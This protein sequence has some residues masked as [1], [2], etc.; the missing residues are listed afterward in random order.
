MVALS[1]HQYGCRVVQRLLEHC[2][3]AKQRASVLGE[4]LRATPALAQDQYGNYVVQHVLQH[5]PPAHQCAL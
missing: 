4:V 3:M 2:T 1:T 5:N